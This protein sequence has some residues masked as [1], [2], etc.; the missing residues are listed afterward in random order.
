MKFSVRFHNHFYAFRV[1]RIVGL[2]ESSSFSVRHHPPKVS[3]CTKRNMRAKDTS[4][5]DHP[6]HVAPAPAFAKFLC[7][8]SSFR[9]F[10]AYELGY[11]WFP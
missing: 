3:N 11:N 6:I 7:G 9:P 2:Y 10:V 8:F 4:P 1:L 5:R